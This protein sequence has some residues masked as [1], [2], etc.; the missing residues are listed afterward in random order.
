MELCFILRHHLF[1]PRYRNVCATPERR[2]HI[3]GLDSSGNGRAAAGADIPSCTPR[4]TRPT[5]PRLRDERRDMQSSESRSA[6]ISEAEAHC[7]TGLMHL[8]VRP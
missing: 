4:T 6:E 3:V 2:R 7:G 5:S 8:L 1:T